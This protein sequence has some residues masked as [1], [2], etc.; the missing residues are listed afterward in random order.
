M[1]AGLFTV[2]AKWNEGSI[3]VWVCLGQFISG[4]LYGQF[5]DWFVLWVGLGVVGGISVDVDTFVSI[6]Q[7]KYF[8]AVEKGY[9]Q[10]IRSE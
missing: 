9:N 10:E 2:K 7:K 8:E 6:Y 1:F 4:V 5:G 3:L